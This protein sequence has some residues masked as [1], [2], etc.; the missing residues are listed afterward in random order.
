[1][2]DKRKP[3]IKAYAEKERVTKGEAIYI[4]EFLIGLP[5]DASFFGRAL[6]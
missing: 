1:M 5:V 2:A 3:K 6:E 4:S